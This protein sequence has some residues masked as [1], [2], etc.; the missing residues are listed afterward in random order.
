MR[1]SVMNVVGNLSHLGI[2]ES[3]WQEEN[4]KCA[5]RWGGPNRDQRSSMGQDAQ[6]I[7]MSPQP[8]AQHYSL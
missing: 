8:E 5:N 4:H 1:N 6:Q 2:H 3:P 7:R